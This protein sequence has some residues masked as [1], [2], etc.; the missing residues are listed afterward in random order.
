MF[1][2]S[3]VL[4]KL[5]TVKTVHIQGWSTTLQV[6]V[7]AWL[8]FP[9]QERRKRQNAARNN[10]APPDQ[11]DDD[12]DDEYEWDDD[13]DSVDGH[14]YINTRDNDE[15]RAVSLAHMYEDPYETINI[16]EY[17][18]VCEMDSLN[19]GGAFSD[20]G[21]NHVRNPPDAMRAVS[22]D[23]TNPKSVF[24]ATGMPSCLDETNRKI[25]TRV[26]NCNRGSSAGPHPRYASM[27]TPPSDDVPPIGQ[28]C[29]TTYEGA[30]ALLG[31][32]AA[33]RINFASTTDP[34]DAE[35]RGEV[36]LTQYRMVKAPDGEIAETSV[37]HYPSAN[38]SAQSQQMAMHAAHIP[39]GPNP[40]VPN[41]EMTNTGASD[42]VVPTGDVEVTEYQTIQTPEGAT[43]ETSVVTHPEVSA[44][45]EDG[46]VG[47]EVGVTVYSQ[48]R[49]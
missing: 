27:V 16:P 20:A 39:K 5:P 12:A 33:T 44:E 47:G 49:F 11:G 45:P 35:V 36:C 28:V 41:V 22:D 2:I 42:E 24:R 48:A 3:N 1:S 38:M 32:P 34:D 37:V 17:D 4:I 13:W 31:A 26:A 30:D 40:N 9:T 6:F 23:N 29:S 7:I 46:D 43:E 19:P 25:P 18:E 21:A 15:N 14:S 10:Q 8:V